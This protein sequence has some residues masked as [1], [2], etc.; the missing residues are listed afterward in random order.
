MSQL[1]SRCVDSADDALGATLQGHCL[2]AAVLPGVG[3]LDPSSTLEPV[4]K[5]NEGGLLNAQAGGNFRLGHG[6]GGE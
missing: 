4:Q 2:A 6:L 1:A 5:V 3:S